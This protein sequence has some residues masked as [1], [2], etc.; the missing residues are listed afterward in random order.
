MNP[1]RCVGF[2]LGCVLLLGA[3]AAVA[4]LYEHESYCDGRYNKSGAPYVQTVED[5]IAPLKIGDKPLLT[6]TYDYGGGWQV[7]IGF[8]NSR[9][10]VLHFDAPLPPKLPANWQSSVLQANG[11]TQSWKKVAYDVSKYSDPKVADQIAYFGSSEWYVRN[12]GA[13][14]YPRGSRCLRLETKEAF[15][16]A[17]QQHLQARHPKPPPAPAF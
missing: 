14:A 9:A 8:I 11:G 4:R 15:G 16:T 6:R 7:R 12:D 10:H 13:V 3:G 1:S 17:Y 2:V 5:R